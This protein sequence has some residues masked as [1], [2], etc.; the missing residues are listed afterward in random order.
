MENLEVYKKSQ[1]KTSNIYKGMKSCTLFFEIIF[2]PKIGTREFRLYLDM[3]I[4]NDLNREFWIFNK[5]Q[6]AFKKLDKNPKSLE[7]FQKRNPNKYSLKAFIQ[8]YPIKI[9]HANHEK[10]LKIEKHTFARDKNTKKSIN[11][12]IDIFYKNSFL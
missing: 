5:F 7:N 2:P 8:K 3:E 6:E 9:H 12:N 10:S 4:L 1:L 11:F